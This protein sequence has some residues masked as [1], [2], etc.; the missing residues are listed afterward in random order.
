MLTIG[1]ATDARTALCKH[2]HAEDDWHV[3]NGSMLLSHLTRLEDDSLCRQLDF[4]IKHQFIS[5]TC[6]SDGHDLLIVRIYL[7]PHDLPNVQGRLR[8]RKASVLSPAKRHLSSLI[9]EL[10]CCSHAWEG[11][12]C[13]SCQTSFIPETRDGLTLAEI[14][15]DLPSPEPKLAHGCEDVNSRLL[16]WNDDLQGFGMRSRLY[17]YQRRSVATLIQKEMDPRPIPD[18]LYASKVDL[19]G[20]VFYYQPGKSEVYREQPMVS[21]ARGGI[22]C[23]ELGTGK[24]VMILTLIVSTIREMSSPEES[25]QDDRPLMTPLAFRHFPSV[26]ETARKRLPFAQRGSV[27]MQSDD[28]PSLVEILLHHGRAVPSTS[29]PNL[30]TVEGIKRHKKQA[31]LEEHIELTPIAALWYANAPFYLHY[32]GPGVRSQ[33]KP[34]DGPRLMYL[35]PATLIVVPP[36]LLSQWDREIIKHCSY[37]LRVLILR[38]GTRVPSAKALASDY[39]IILTTYTSFTAEANCRDISKLYPWKMCRCP[40]FQGSRVPDCQCKS[41]EVSPFFQIRWKRLVIDEG[42]VSASFSTNL[43]QM[44]RFLS[45]ERRWI[46]TGTPTTNLLGLNFGN[47]SGEEEI[48][49]ESVSDEAQGGYDTYNAYE[50]YTPSRKPILSPSLSSGSSTPFD[51]P[52]RSTVARIWNKYDREDLYKLWNMITHFVVVPHLSAESKSIYN[53]II[54]PLLDPRGPRP[55]AIQVLVQVMRMV[56]VRHCVQ[57]IEND[58]S[59]PPVTHQ[60]VTLDLEPQAIKSFNVMQA[61]IVINAIDS[62]RTGQDYMF[63]PRNANFL[64]QTVKVMSQLMLWSIDKSHFYYVDGLLEDEDK[65]IQR[66]IER[67]M[68]Q[69]DMQLLQDAFRHIHLAAEDSLWKALQSHEDV[70]YHVS[71]MNPQVYN[72]WTRTPQKDPEMPMMNG[73]IHVDRLIKLHEFVMTHQH[74][75]GEDILIGQGRHVASDD[76][77]LQMLFEEEKRKKTKSSKWAR[78]HLPDEHSSKLVDSAVKKAHA[79]DTLKEMQKELHASI[80]HPENE[81]AS[82]GRNGV[83]TSSISHPPTATSDFSEALAASPLAKIYIGHSA[84]SKINWIINEV[85]TYSSK[86][87]FLI[88]SDSELSLAHVAEALDLIRVKYLRFTAQIDARHREQMVLTFETSET[89]RVFLMELKHGARGLNLISAS[90]IIFCEPIWQ[91]DVESQAIKRAHRIGQTKE[92]TVTTLAIRGTA[93]ERMVTRRELFKGSHDRIPKLI[94]EAGMR[95]FIANPKFIEDR[96]QLLTT[97]DEPLFN[98]KRQVEDSNPQQPS[99]RME[100][101]S[102]PVTIKQPRF[103]NVSF[104]QPDASSDEE[105]SDG[106]YSSRQGLESPKDSLYGTTPSRAARGSTMLSSQS[107]TRRRTPHSNGLNTKP[108]VSEDAKSSPEKKRRVDSA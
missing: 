60:S 73:F 25:L 17:Q 46:V 101:Q 92:I 106:S 41:P 4:L 15:G 50:E 53:D 23:E 36:N 56:M 79:A 89:Y 18:P 54:N 74:L 71:H 86:E 34:V 70:P 69:E 27:S 105:M 84:S 28:F 65:Y 35:T 13:K 99:D 37:P 75:V 103:K 32:E 38:T 9:S 16:D 108:T 11:S 21:P 33:R 2:L 57:D 104:V 82:T 31:A 72:A 97:V 61:G 78:H 14:Y 29:I 98:I 85:K 1:V 90:R 43:I 58:V 20:E 44:V 81:T 26:Y 5:A 68:P 6:R 51:S 93:E 102:P 7:I 52:P 88:F 59:I 40:A 8:M 76:E 91:A 39:D 66:A 95:H 67:N 22:L 47:N 100:D 48:D 3:F 42:H 55:G 10:K 62:Q 94:E 24:T 19:R 107:A 83:T 30:T 87:K 63:Y 96:P 12:I 45:V 80:A 49:P 77:E 64:Q